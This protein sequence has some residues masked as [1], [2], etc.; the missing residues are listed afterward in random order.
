MQQIFAG[1]EEEKE[2]YER[3]WCGWTDRSLCARHSS[4]W[5]ERF[6]PSPE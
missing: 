1:E 3:R 5:Q 6:D 2:F 4:Y